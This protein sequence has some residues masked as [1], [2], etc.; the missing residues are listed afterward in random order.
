MKPCKNLPD[1]TGHGQKEYKVMIINIKYKIIKVKK[2]INPVRF[3]PVLSGSV[4]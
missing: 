1:R 3:C 4:F 2:D